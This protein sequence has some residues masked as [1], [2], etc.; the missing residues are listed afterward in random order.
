[1]R[2][3]MILGVA[4]LTLVSGGVVA[5]LHA[6]AAVTPSARPNAVNDNG[7]IVGVAT[8]AAGESHAVLWSAAAPRGAAPTDLG[9]LGGKS[10]NARAI[11]NHGQ[12]VGTL[13]TANNDMR[14]FLW[15]ATDGMTTL[16]GPPGSANGCEAN[17]INDSGQIAGYCVF[18]SDGA[19]DV[20]GA[21]AVVWTNGQPTI[22]E[23]TGPNRIQEGYAL[24]I[25]DNGDVYGTSGDTAVVW[26]GS[27]RTVL[28][29]GSTFGDDPGAV[30]DRGDAVGN[31]FFGHGRVYTL[32][33]AGTYTETD[34]G[35][36]T[37]AYDI[38]DNGVVVG[39]AGGDGVLAPRGFVWSQGTTTPIGTLGG[40]QSYAFGINNHGVIVGQSTLA[41]K[42]LRGFVL[43]DG[44]MTVLGS[45][46]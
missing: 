44:T 45:L 21:K 7:D 42:E 14:A 11:N 38:N 36:H 29:T 5:A 19:P 9:A 24:S 39:Y 4:T 18:D 41:S 26:N 23:V 22:F 2:R 8:T 35:A 20:D 46:F 1:M 40:T 25:N 43:E 6:T 13:T 17:A 28:G 12:V 30:N 31:V 37:T 10:S 3:M 33:T 32:T 15:T 34:L 16:T 27:T